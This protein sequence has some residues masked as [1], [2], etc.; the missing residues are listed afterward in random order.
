MNSGEIPRSENVDPHHR[1]STQHTKKKKQ[2]FADNAD[3]PSIT[4]VDIHK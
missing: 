4:N 2:K 3:K 1:L